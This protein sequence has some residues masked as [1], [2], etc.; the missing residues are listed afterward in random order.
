M[1]YCWFSNQRTSFTVSFRVTSSH[2]VSVGRQSSGQG[3]P[4]S[5]RFPLSGCLA[6]LYSCQ[7][8]QGHQ[9]SKPGDRKTSFVTSLCTCCWSVLQTTSIHPSVDDCS[10][11]LKREHSGNVRRGAPRSPPQIKNLHWFYG[12]VCRR[13]TVGLVWVE[14][15]DSESLVSKMVIFNLY[16]PVA[17]QTSE[18]LWKQ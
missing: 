14:N 2:P 15:P 17:V 9:E 16:L 12:L 1:V 8:Y 7:G 10:R 13:N 4:R 11:V 3:F 6:G 18:R 5:S